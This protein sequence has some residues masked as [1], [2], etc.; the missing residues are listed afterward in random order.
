MSWREKLGVPE[1]DDRSDT[2]TPSVTSVITFRYKPN[3]DSAGE[4]LEPGSPAVACEPER[5]LPWAEWKAV[6]L[7]QLFRD[8]GVT[9]QTGQIT[10]ATVRHGEAAHERVD[11]VGTHEPP[12]SRAEEE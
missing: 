9:G 8:Q 11:S 4:R 5:S 10:A 2:S 12:M 1:T 7:N 3:I 6:A